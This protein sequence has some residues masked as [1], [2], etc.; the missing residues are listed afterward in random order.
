MLDSQTTKEQKKPSLVE[1]LLPESEALT[2][3][4]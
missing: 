3:I 4:L 2:P 1:H